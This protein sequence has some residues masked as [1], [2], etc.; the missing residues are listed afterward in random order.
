M[1]FKMQKLKQSE[2]KQYKAI[3]IILIYLLSGHI[4]AQ[5]INKE[6]VVTSSFRPEIE[7]FEK[8]SLMPEIKDTVTVKPEI[9]I[10][11]VPS[12][13]ETYY[14]VRPIKAATIAANPL[15]KLYNSYL[16][17]GM[18]MYTTPLVEFN[19]HNLRSK[20]YS[21]G[22]YASHKSS[23]TKIK[24]DNGHKVPGGYGKNLI[25][26]Y[27]KHFHK[28]F[29]L[30]GDAGFRNHKIR[31]YGYNTEK[32]E[33]QELPS[34]ETFNIGQNYIDVFANAAIY[35]RDVDS[36][37]VFFYRFALSGA[38][39]SDSDKNDEGIGNIKGLLGGKA[40]GLNIALN[41]GL[42]R[43]NKGFASNIPDNTVF[44][45]NPYIQKKSDLWEFKIGG[46]LVIDKD[47]ITNQYF[48]PDANIRFYIM[49][50]VLQSYFGLGGDLEL[51]NYK[52][53][54]SENPF[55]K[56]GI[57]VPNTKKTL[58]AYGGLIGEI[59][60]QAGFRIEAR[61][62]SLKDA[63]Y[64]IINK[65]A[66]I[67]SLDNQFIYELDNSDLAQLKGEIYYNPL[68][69]LSFFT[70]ASFNQYNVK[71]I[72]KP[73]HK[74]AFEFNFSTKYIHE[75]K[76]VTGFELF[77]MSKRYAPPSL[78]TSNTNTT[79]NAIWDVNLMAEYQYSN[80]LSFFAD[81]NNIFGTK[82]YVWS[83]YPT[84]GFNFMLG[85]SYKL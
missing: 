50:S 5:E 74:P 49:P 9:D 15:D 16:K 39:F 11:L 83:Q 62:T 79:L 37:N 85:L 63:Y 32:F 64:Y 47:T 76:L 14:N 20:K 48:Y 43:I 40:G 80:V 70:K 57:Y 26:G 53:I 56:P 24:L 29:T 22:G 3:Y 60:S 35:S 21:Y 6:V 58:I 7:Q 77:H 12:R 82:Y 55:V 45:V 38:Y 75:E 41:L 81:V 4:C 44:T 42:D 1:S 68:K 59:T 17:L 78:V 31:Y 34:I 13:V 72:D 10:S 84:Q 23:H 66:Q 46:K 25:G 52:K 67:N 69:N 30:E 51:N 61:Y 73:W 54:A 71:S 65:Q 33:G 36:N 2:M 27:G 8:I 18:G 28:D 19:I